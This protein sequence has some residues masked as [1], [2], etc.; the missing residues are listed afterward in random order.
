[1]QDIL[2][3]GDS[4]T[5]GADPLTARRFSIHDRWPGVLRDALGPDFHII[6]E[7]LSGRTTVWDDPIDEYRNGKHH[8]LPTLWSH[9]PLD[10][11]I[12]MLGTND[13]KGRVCR[14]A[15][16]IAAGANHLV[17]MTLRSGAGPDD[18]P[19][20]VLLICP[21]PL[22]KITALAEMWGFGDAEKVSRELAGYYMLVAQQN[23]CGFLDA[24][25]I[26]VSSDLDGV[27]FDRE[28]HHKLGKAV[29][30]KVREMLDK[31]SKPQ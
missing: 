3:F 20:Q 2:C 9:M 5:W 6:E 31:A 18:G 30:S 4:N 21:P 7:G 11:V 28:E 14:R 17:G 19:P 26:I 29:A 25:E 24:G 15:T 13:L 27:H 12:I 8:I 10:L 16:D 23:R 1:M 22:G